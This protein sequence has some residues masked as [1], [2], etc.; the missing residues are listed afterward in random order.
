[1]LPTY[2]ID[3]GHS[4]S[5]TSLDIAKDDADEQ[6]LFRDCRLNSRLLVNEK[7]KEI[8][9]SVLGALR[10]SKSEKF[11]QIVNHCQDKVYLKKIFNKGSMQDFLKMLRSYSVIT[12][13]ESYYLTPKIK[14]IPIHLEVRTIFSHLENVILQIRKYV[15]QIPSK[16]KNE[17]KSVYEFEE[18]I[19]DDDVTSMASQ[20][21]V[22]FEGSRSSKSAR[23]KRSSKSVI[24][25]ASQIP[26]K[27]SDFLESTASSLV[28]RSYKNFVSRNI[29]AVEGKSVTRKIFEDQEP[30]NISVNMYKSQFLKKILSADYFPPNIRHYVAP[31]KISNVSSDTLEEIVEKQPEE[32]KT[33]EVLLKSIFPEKC[34][35]IKKTSCCACQEK[36]KQ[37]LPS[38]KIPTYKK[39]GLDVFEN[40]FKTNR[41]N[42][43]SSM[44]NEELF[45]LDSYDSRYSVNNKNIK[46]KIL[47]NP[48]AITA[49]ENEVPTVA[50]SVDISPYDLARIS[51]EIAEKETCKK[52]NIFLQESV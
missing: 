34:S 22:I 7:I 14:Q 39:F 15:L 13:C 19:I 36:W 43:L 46:M 30:N 5:S 40:P 45:R 11:A 35:F 3:I 16:T 20:Q 26:K 6:K 18:D 10:K 27:K 44:I 47:K 12:S 42:Q 24:S 2:V 33:S 25:K 31:S 28:T 9:V 8:L 32:D 29:Q 37:C 38:P 48:S 17:W 41:L 23:A 52:L 49:P 4:F 1:M 50:D 51:H 21:M